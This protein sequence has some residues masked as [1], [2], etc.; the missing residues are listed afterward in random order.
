MGRKKLTDEERKI[1][2]EKRLQYLRDYRKE[3]GPDY[4]Q[5]NKERILQQQRK[6][7]EEIKGAPLRKLTKGVNIKQM[8]REEY[9]EYCRIKIRESRARKKAEQQAEGK[10][11][12]RGRPLKQKKEENKMKE[13]KIRFV[14][15]SD[16]FTEITIKIEDIKKYIDKNIA[17]KEYITYTDEKEGR[18]VVINLKNVFRVE[19]EEV[20]GDD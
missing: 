5:K 4:Y 3:H 9:N 19:F 15:N 10:E 17:S 7:R 1:S 18:T 20:K 13:Y 14:E 8:T 12:K 2:R 16:T 11:I 6:K